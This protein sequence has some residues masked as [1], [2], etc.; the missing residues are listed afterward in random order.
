ML[1]WNTLKQITYKTKITNDTTKT[2][3][4]PIKHIT[5]T[6]TGAQRRKGWGRRVVGT[7][8]EKAFRQFASYSFA[9]SKRVDLWINFNVAVNTSF[10]Y[11]KT[12]SWQRQKPWVPFPLSSGDQ[13]ME[14]LSW[15]LCCYPIVG[16]K[17]IKQLTSSQQYDV[18]F[19]NHLGII[20]TSIPI[21]PSS[22]KKP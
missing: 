7:R 19:W 12:N 13:K 8:R 18:C 11:V 20:I 22:Y 10:V 14:K 9:I 4:L 2:T 6:Q 15:Q 1:T 5:K 3:K 16:S 21:L 17:Q